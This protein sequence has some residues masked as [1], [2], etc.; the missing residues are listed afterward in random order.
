MQQGIEFFTATCLNWQKLLL[1]DEHK[2]IILDSLKFLVN[3]RRIWLYG[4]VI[5]PNHI[6]ILW[7]KQPD[8][9]NKNVQQHFTKYTAQ[10]LKFSL[11]NSGADINSYKSTQNDRE[12]QFWERRPYKAT[13]YNRKVLEEKLDYIHNNPVKAQLCTF[14][15]DY[16]YSSAN[17]YIQNEPHELITHY[18][19]HI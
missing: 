12:Y 3:D 17:Y 14:P 5:M 18:M 7:C 19:E 6:H 10:Q 4:Y 11:I 9:L 8:W 15:E 16:K 1:K 2:Q 13:M